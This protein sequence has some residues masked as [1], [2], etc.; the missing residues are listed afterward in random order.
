MRSLG[1]WSKR[2]RWQERIAGAAS[3][4]VEELHARSQEWDETAFLRS[5]ET[6]AKEMSEL[7]EQIAGLE[8]GNLAQK[9][10]L[11]TTVSRLNTMRLPTR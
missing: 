6:L 9:L 5:S 4:R 7:A 11:I 2:Y 3:A 1:D 8:P 10:T